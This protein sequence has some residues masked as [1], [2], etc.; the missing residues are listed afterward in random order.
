MKKVLI[1]GGAGFIGSYLVRY[2]CEQGDAQIDVVD[3]F[4]RH[5]E[6]DTKNISRENVQYINMDVATCF[7]VTLL[8]PEY[9]ETFLLAS[10][11]GVDFVLEHP[12]FVLTQN[13]AIIN[14]VFAWLSSGATKKFLFTSTSEVYAGAVE[15][16]ICSIPTDE[17]VPVVIQDITHPRFTYAVTK[18]YGESLFTNAAKEF[19]LD[20]FIVRYHNVY[21]PDM[22]NRHVLP[23]LVER[24][25]SENPFTIYGGSQTRSFNHVND[26]VRAT[27]LVM[28]EGER[29]QIYHIGTDVETTI[30][31]LTR[32]VGSLLGYS[33]EYT[34]GDAYPGSVNRRSPNIAKVRSL[35]YEPTIGWQEGVAG[36]V[37][38]RMNSSE[39]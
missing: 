19:N 38:S 14:N 15:E 18:A 34:V 39:E 13:V 10:V 5:S 17:D 23:H 37:A 36:Y 11:V 31:E 30:D 29:G 7:D 3:N 28:E 27:V 12:T 22:G 6:Q 16:K 25:K 35:G 21:G 33:G 24:F 8:K 20:V 26:A 32:Y 9:D 1:I 4:S 2:I